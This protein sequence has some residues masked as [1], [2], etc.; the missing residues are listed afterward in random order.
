MNILMFT[1]VIVR[2]IKICLDL[3]SLLLNTVPYEYLSKAVSLDPQ[4]WCAGRSS[5][6]SINLLV[7]ISKS[8]VSFDVD[9]I[10]FSHQFTTS[11]KYSPISFLN[12]F[13]PLPKQAN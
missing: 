3:I 11:F 9:N 10:I 5:H 8:S 6:L 4:S 13:I 1:N 7:A 12:H 2:L